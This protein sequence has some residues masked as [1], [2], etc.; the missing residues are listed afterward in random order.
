MIIKLVIGDPSGDGHDKTADRL[1]T[2]NATAVEVVEAY[3][4]GVDTIGV[5]ITEYCEEYED[6]TV[7]QEVIEKLMSYGLELEGTLISRLKDCTEPETICLYD[8]EYFDAYIITAL[9]GNPT[10]TFESVALEEVEIGGYGL[11]G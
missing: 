6:S 7:P 1:Y 3:C 2:V 4:K 8:Q 5:D 11:F 9:I 10:L